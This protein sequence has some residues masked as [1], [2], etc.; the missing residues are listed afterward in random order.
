MNAST[1]SVRMSLWNQSAG[2]DPKLNLA[3]FTMR[4]LNE[5]REANRFQ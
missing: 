3:P 4:D 2:L 5:L 1:A